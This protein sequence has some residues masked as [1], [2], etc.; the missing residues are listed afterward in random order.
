VDIC[1]SS[2][3]RLIFGFF[4]FCLRF[5]FSFVVDFCNALA[6]PHKPRVSCIKQG[7]LRH[8]FLQLASSS[9]KDYRS[10]PR[11]PA[12]DKAFLHTICISDILLAAAGL[13]FK[14]MNISSSSNI[15]A[16][17]K[18]LFHWRWRTEILD[19]SWVWILN[20]LAFAFLHTPFA[21]DWIYVVLK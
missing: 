13:R 11:L 10:T 3:L 18:K 17:C 2:F 4:W 20:S 12:V 16:L 15:G 14:T 21:L 8:S 1:R 5:S 7:R 6:T 19:F 9:S